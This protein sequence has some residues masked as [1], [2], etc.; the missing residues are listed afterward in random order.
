M[1]DKDGHPESQ[2]ADVREKVDISLEI[3]IAGEPVQFTITI[4]SGPATWEDL[5][6]F[7]RSL[8]Q[9]GTDIS[10]DFHQTQG[11]EISCRAGCGVCCRQ[12][13]PLAPFEAHRLRRLVEGMPEP[14]RSELLNRFAANEKQV[15]EAADLPLSY[16]EN[17]TPEQ[18]NDSSVGYFKM[19]MPCPFLEDESCSIHADRPLKCREY[20]VTSP[21]ENCATPYESDIDDLPLP[22]GVYLTTMRLDA[23]PTKPWLRGVPMDQLL[24]WTDS[25]EPEPA[26][27]TGPELLNE[28][29]SKLLRP[30]QG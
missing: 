16:D 24:T 12:R 26:E 23:D 4:P 21:A 14:R 27:R 28:F 1:S 30:S 3:R 15:R 11:R 20:L 25:H 29:L 10:A 6:P 19:M 7:M 17:L 9:V 5:L 2:A 8:V 13:V 18:M 22:L